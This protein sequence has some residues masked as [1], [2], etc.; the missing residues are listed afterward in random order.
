[1]TKRKV[2][3]TDLPPSDPAAKRQAHASATAEVKS[4]EPMAGP[5]PALAPKTKR[6]A[7]P[8]KA[9]AKKP[10]PNRA[11]TKKAAPKKAAKNLAEAEAAAEEAAAGAAKSSLPAAVEPAS[12]VAAEAREG[13]AVI[14]EPPVPVAE[15]PVVEPPTA[16]AASDPP[17][18]V[19]ET[20]AAGP[21]PAATTATRRRSWPNYLANAQ[22]AFGLASIQ[23]LLAQAAPMPAP[24]PASISHIEPAAAS[25]PSG[26]T[27]ASQAS[28]QAYAAWLQE[29]ESSLTRLLAEAK[30]QEIIDWELVGLTQP[31]RNA[32]MVLRR[33]AQTMMKE[34]EQV[35]DSVCDMQRRYEE[36][37]K[38]A[39]EMQITGWV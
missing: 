20:A 10:A 9:A 6:T 12:G 21:R 39:L 28:L 24:A 19:A 16:T 13:S 18:A 14:M 11:A 7:A 36:L 15:T 8:K 27:S 33:R 25:R 22:P 2:D 35:Q 29:T 17:A 38:R 31:M 3:Q 30:G 32:A 26:P 23:P 5:P 4:A 37:R 1:M 34:F